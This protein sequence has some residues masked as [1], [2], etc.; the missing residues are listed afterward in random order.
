ML[1]KNRCKDF[2]QSVKELQ[3]QFLA[4]NAWSP[5]I[6][7]CRSALYQHTGWLYRILLPEVELFLNVVFVVIFFFLGLTSCVVTLYVHWEEGIKD[8]HNCT[9]TCRCLRGLTN[10]KSLWSPLMPVRT[11]LHK[12]LLPQ[13]LHI[14]HINVKLQLWKVRLK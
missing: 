4:E 7:S 3:I 1:W 11:T 13:I 6:K 9:V 10:S 8:S 2:P 12:S 5:P 14:Y